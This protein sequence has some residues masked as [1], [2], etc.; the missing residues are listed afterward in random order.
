MFIRWHPINCLVDL[1]IFVAFLGVYIKL[2]LVGDKLGI[3][4]FCTNATQYFSFE[5][6]TF[7]FAGLKDTL[8]KK[9][10]KVRDGIN[11]TPALYYRVQKSS[12]II[13]H[14]LFLSQRWTDEVKG[15]APV[16]ELHC[17]WT[18]F[19]ELLWEWINLILLNF[20]LM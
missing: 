16:E 6:R 11:Y 4:L 9:R 19:A 3:Q 20:L 17:W 1:R 10:R 12:H 18:D 15:S 2:T 5:E 8:T 14:R 13:R 7:H